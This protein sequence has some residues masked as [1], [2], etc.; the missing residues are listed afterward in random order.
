MISANI[1]K[2]QLEG[3]ENAIHDRLWATVYYIDRRTAAIASLRYQSFGKYKVRCGFASGIQTGHCPFSWLNE[4][5]RIY[6]LRSRP[7]EKEI[8]RTF[9]VAPVKSIIENSWIRPSKSE[10]ARRDPA[11]DLLFVTDQLR[12]SLNA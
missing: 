1:R 4:R 12:R 6:P 10:V 8:D 5:Q 3:A 2:Q 7:V 9:K 11:D